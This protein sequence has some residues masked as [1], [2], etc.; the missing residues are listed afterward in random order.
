MKKLSDLKGELQSWQDSVKI[1]TIALNSAKL[2]Y[3]AE[4]KKR[5][6]S[7]RLYRI[8]IKSADAE[9]VSLNKNFRRLIRELREAKN[10]VKVLSKKLSVYPSQVRSWSKKHM[11]KVIESMEV[12]K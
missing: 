1:R 11:G 5:E 4:I 8:Y 6:V 2:N 7:K 12:A 10:K 9:I 3:P